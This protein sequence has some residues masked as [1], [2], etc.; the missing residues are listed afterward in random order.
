LKFGPVPRH[1]QHSNPLG[2]AKEQMLRLTTN[3][4]SYTHKHSFNCHLLGKGQTHRNIKPRAT[5]RQLKTHKDNHRLRMTLEAILQS[6]LD[7][8]RW[9]NTLTN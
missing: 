3:A 9:L 8:D 7:V 4:Q 1:T 2:L 5:Q 6:A